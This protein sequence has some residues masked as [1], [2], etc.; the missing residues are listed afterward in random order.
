MKDSAALSACIDEELAKLISTL[1]IASM[2]KHALGK[3][4]SQALWAVV[5]QAKATAV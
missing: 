3:S 2:A 4:D 5:S 1:E